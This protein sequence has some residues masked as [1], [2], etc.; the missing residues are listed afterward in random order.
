MDVLHLIAA[1]ILVEI[2]SEAAL[3]VKPWGTSTRTC[4]TTKP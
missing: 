3:F 4:K 2:T 1:R